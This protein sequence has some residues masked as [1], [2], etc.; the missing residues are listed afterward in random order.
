M[1]ELQRENSNASV[2]VAACVD[3]STGSNMTECTPAQLPIAF[4][5]GLG[6]EGTSRIAMLMVWGFYK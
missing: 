3:T 5:R 2:T 6:T 1:S 4:G